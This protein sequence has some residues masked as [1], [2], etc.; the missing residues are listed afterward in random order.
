VQRDSLHY[1]SAAETLEISPHGGQLSTQLSE[2]APLRELGS[3]TQLAFDGQRMYPPG[4]HLAFQL[5]LVGGPQSSG[6]L[7][8]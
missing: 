3:L 8:R 6:V 1:R 2:L 7:G 4:G 5:K